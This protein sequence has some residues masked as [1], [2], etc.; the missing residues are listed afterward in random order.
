MK[1]ICIIEDDTGI[2]NSLKLYLESSNFEVKLYASGTGAVDFIVNNN[3]HLAILDI[4]LPGING[5]E[6]CRILREQSKIPIIMLTARGGEHD[7]IEGLES[8]A[9]DYVAKPFSPREL[10][11]RINVLLRRNYSDIEEEGKETITF[12]NIRIYT[13]SG[14]VKKGEDMI[15]FT[16]N[17]YDILVKIANAKGNIVSRESLMKEVIGYDNYVYDRTIDTHIKNIRKKLGTG[18]Y[19]ITVRGKGYKIKI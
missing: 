3:P 10:L 11:A 13:E 4:N 19:I 5:I 14:E 8:G 9:D 7:R 2:S 16:K 12:Q 1:K 18:E 17:E 15:A 6:V